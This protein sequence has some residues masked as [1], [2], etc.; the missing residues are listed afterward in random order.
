MTEESKGDI[1]IK[2][3]KSYHNNLKSQGISWAVFAEHEFRLNQ[4][5]ANITYTA[6]KMQPI[7]IKKSE[8]IDDFYDVMAKPFSKPYIYIISGRPDDVRACCVAAMLLIQASIV[9]TQL[10]DNPDHPDSVY[11]RLQRPQW[12]KLSNDFKDNLH[13]PSWK[14]SFLVLSNITPLS[15]NVKYEKVRDIL[16][17][18]DNI[19]R[20]VV[21]ND[22]DPI[23]YARTKAFIKPDYVMML[24]QGKKRLEV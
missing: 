3:N 18:H 10:R 9:H 15:S 16:E 24:E 12:V 1:K 23:A 5:V 11:G 8:Q 22:I 21:V 13:N 6:E 4:A 2:I 19:P 14:P 20:V 17:F 7:L